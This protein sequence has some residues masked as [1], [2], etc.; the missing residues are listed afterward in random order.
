MLQ[1]ESVLDMEKM[2]H[3]YRRPNPIAARVKHDEEKNFMVMKSGFYINLI[4]EN[5][6]MVACYQLDD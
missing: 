5:D 3:P 1:V 2:T 6:E 4:W